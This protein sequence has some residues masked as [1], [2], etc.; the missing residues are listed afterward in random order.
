ME[1]TFLDRKFGFGAICMVFG[2]GFRVGFMSVASGL[3]VAS[4]SVCMVATLA[5]Q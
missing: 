4:M 3:G 2:T 1:S 5:T